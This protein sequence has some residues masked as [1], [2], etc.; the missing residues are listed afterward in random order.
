MRPDFAGEPA[1]QPAPDRPRRRP[2]AAALFERVVPDDPPTMSFGRAKP[3][4]VD[5]T[6]RMS[7]SAP[8]EDPEPP[9]PTPPDEQLTIPLGSDD[10]TLPLDRDC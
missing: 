6:L 7:S 1:P 10:N 5:A 4:D 2:S 8:A 3:A 9:E